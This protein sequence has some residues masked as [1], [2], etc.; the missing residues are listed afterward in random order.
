MEL[1]EF[2][3]L[4][5]RPWLMCAIGVTLLLG[6]SVVVAA[7]T[8]KEG[9][10]FFEKNI[11]PV[12]AGS[13]YKCHSAA[14]KAKQKLAAN[15]CLDSWTGIAHGGQSGVAVVVRGAPDK[16]LLIKAIRY[17]YTGDYEDQNMPP[18][19][20]DGGGGKL[21]DE[22]ISRFESWVE[23][24]APYPEEAREG[25]AAP[26]EKSHWAFQAPKWVAVPKVKDA[27][28]V[29]NPVDAFVISTLENSGLKLSS[30]ADKR[31]LLRRAT[32]D[33]TGLPPTPAEVEEFLRD[34]SPGAFGKVVDR[35]L[36][37]PRYGERWGR[38]W[39]DVARYSDTKGYVFEEERRYPY[40][41]TY[42]D[43]VIQAF[44]S[45]LPFDQFLIQQIAAD[46]LDLG[47]DNGALAA[48]GFLTLG[49]RFLNNPPDIIDD[50]LD[51]I[52]RGTMGLTIGCARCHDHKFDPIPTSD[53]YSLYG[54]LDSSVEPKELPLLRPAASTSAALAFEKELKSRQAAVEAYKNEQ[55]RVILEAAGKPTAIAEYLLGAR[56]TV[57]DGGDGKDDLI[58]H[59]LVRYRAMLASA[60]PRHAVFGP[61]HVYGALPE[62]DFAARSA[63]ATHELFAAAGPGRK[64][65]FNTLIAQAFVDKPPASM[66]EVAQRYGVVLGRVAGTQKR[67][68]SEEE[69]LR[70]ALY[71][72]QGPLAVAAAEY[73]MLLK[74]E[75]RDK[76]T[77]LQKEADGW[78]ADSPNAPARAMALVDASNPHDSPVHLR[79]N[80]AN[81]GQVVPRHFLTVL[82]RGVP[83]PLTEGSGRLQLARAIADR[84]NPLTARVWVNRVWLYHFGKGIVRTPSDF[85]TRCDP[86]T[87]PELLDWLAL[88][89]MDD[90]WSVKKLQRLILLSATYQ[91][92]SMDNA[93]ARNID[94]ENL[95]L[96]RMNRQ[97]LDFEATR[98]SLLAVVGELDET[99]GGRA[100]NLADT[101]YRRRTIYGAIDRQN[102]P[103]VFRVFDFASPDATSPQRFTTTTPQQALYFMN[104][105]FALRQAR[106][107]A[108]RPEM[109]Q[110]DPQAR[111][112]RFY[113]T[114]FAREASPDEISA[115]VKYLKAEAAAAT[116]GAKQLS[117]WEKYAQVLLESNEFVF[118]D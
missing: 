38:H 55:G 98:D 59:L 69:S 57:I 50:R 91:Q 28:R 106:A 27:A 78:I 11:R 36:A 90:G 32:L 67:A 51:V 81:L 93:A 19:P 26:A 105:P 22:T 2:A 40:A 39:L 92:S 54:V 100:G 97:R 87:H 118:I 73:A 43:W 21:S 99:R 6:P 30:P 4:M 45:D 46:K 15:L 12:L 115:G 44:N 33:L 114:L 49:R 108:A 89:F 113:R 14:A 60:G 3:R 18:K 109:Q 52:G 96:W 16:S 41:Y 47:S 20:Q 107:L 1:L 7:Q 103:S 112:A 62:A 25:L 102:L 75:A 65:E 110:A 111:I 63:Q 117:P 116:G 31:T 74:R 5:R 61:W 35:L 10:D 24:G 80:A 58:H 76:L 82:S 9:V 104:S 23:M 68:T 101:A 48:L 34:S 66:R 85:G 70:L 56:N 29:Q 84:D 8:A 71:G 83:Q 13:C 17:K 88:R 95:L 37:S 42:R 94:P 53:Y 64:S 72:E 79:G 77:G 86:P